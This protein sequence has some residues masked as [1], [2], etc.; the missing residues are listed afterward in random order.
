VLINLGVHTST[1]V[2]L[3]YGAASGWFSPNAIAFLIL[4]TTRLRVYVP[5]N[6]SLRTAQRFWRALWWAGLGKRAPAEAFW[7]EDGSK[8]AISFVVADESWEN[9]ET[10]EKHQVYAAVAAG[11]IGSNPL[12]CH[13][14][15]KNLIIRLTFTVSL[16]DGKWAP[17]SPLVAS[18]Q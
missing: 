11:V 15:D 13:L 10:I 6:Q 18:F 4:A 16:Q 7:S 9:P 1:P 3:L 8:A 2:D 12:T 17:D 14:L 5:K